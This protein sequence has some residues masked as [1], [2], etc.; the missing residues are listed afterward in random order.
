MTCQ[1]GLAKTLQTVH[2]TFSLKHDQKLSFFI[3]VFFFVFFFYIPNR[4]L[5][6]SSDSLVTS[7]SDL[8]ISL[9]KVDTVQ[10]LP[11]LPTSF[12]LASQCCFSHLDHSLLIQSLSIRE[13]GTKTA[14][15]GRC[16]KRNRREE[17][18]GKD[19]HWL[20]LEEE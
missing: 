6:H 10:V 8:L 13:R 7:L 15:T 12:L 17:L 18:F 19:E 1:T 2:E 5:P 14:I 9:R 3:V 16:E 4:L 11:Q 20:F